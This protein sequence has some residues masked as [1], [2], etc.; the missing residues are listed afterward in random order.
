MNET[1]SPAQT[2]HLAKQL[3]KDYGIE[4]VD[5]LGSGELINLINLLHV[6]QYTR[7]Q[8]QMAKDF[9]LDHEMTLRQDL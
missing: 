7:H 9:D 5:K 6:F 8:M 3:L 1:I 4:D 2:N